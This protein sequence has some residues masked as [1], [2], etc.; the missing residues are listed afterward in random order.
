MSAVYVFHN[1]LMSYSIRILQSVHYKSR[2]IYALFANCKGLE[3]FFC[4]RK[5]S[6]S[7]FSQFFAIFSSEKQ[8]RAPRCQRSAPFNHSQQIWLPFVIDTEAQQF[9]HLEIAVAFGRFGTVIKTGM[10]IK[11]GGEITVQ[12]KINGVFPFNTCPLVTGL[13][14]QP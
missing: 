14:V 13:E 12:H 5:R 6:F 7:Y 1:T 9:L 10:H 3:C 2:Q 11:F 8:K 4:V